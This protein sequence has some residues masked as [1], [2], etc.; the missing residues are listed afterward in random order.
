MEGLAV[1]RTMMPRT[2]HGWLRGAAR[3]GEKRA[4]Y[5]RAKARQDNSIDAISVCHGGQR[6]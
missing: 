5:R 1:Q 4:G 6:Q 3:M 2:H